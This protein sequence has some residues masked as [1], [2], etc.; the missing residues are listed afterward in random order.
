MD[1]LNNLLRSTDEPTEQVP[2]L[3]ELAKL[4]TSD[5]SKEKKDYASQ[6]LVIAKQLKSSE[7]L[8]QAHL[9]V[10]NAY[11]VSNDYEKSL[12]HSDSS[13]NIARQLNDSLCIA[14]NLSVLGLTNIDM[15]RKTYP[16]AE[17]YF[18]DALP[19]YQTL[20]DKPGQANCFINLSF[21]VRK[22]NKLKEAIDFA[23]QALAIGTDIN[24]PAILLSVNYQL[25]LCYHRKGNYEEALKAQRSALQLAK[26]LGNERREANTLNQISITLNRTG[27][28]ESSVEHSQKAAQIN[29]A[30]NDTTHWGGN[31]TNMGVSYSRLGSYHKSLEVYFE[32]LKLLES[33][34]DKQGISNAYTNIGKNYK[35]LKEY[36]KAME[37]YNRSIKLK[38][39]LNDEEGAGRVYNNL[40]TT[41]FEQGDYDTALD[42][43]F[44]SLELHKKT[45]FKNSEGIAL[46]NLGEAYQ[47]KQRFAEALDYSY[48]ALDI[49]S[50]IGNKGGMAAALN[51]IADTYIE[52]KKY[53]EQASLFK[54]ENKSAFEIEGMLMQAKDLAE[55]IN[56]FDDMR[57]V[58]IS[59][60][61]FY[62]KDNPEDALIFQDKLI[63]I[64]DSIYQSE[65]LAAATEM[66]TKFDLRNKEKE[67]EF[68]IETNTLI[69]TRNRWYLLMSVA[70]LWLLFIGLYFYVQIRKVKEQ[71]EVQNQTIENQ[72]EELTKLN[73][74]KDRFFGI[75][76]HDLKSPLIALQG[77][78]K[79]ID[80]L[81]RNNERDQLLA[82]GNQVDG[83][84]TK[85]NNLLDNLLHW[86]SIQSGNI[87]YQPQRLNVLDVAED[88][89]DLFENNAASKGVD[90][91]MDISPDLHIHADERAVNTI[92]RNLISNA[93]KFTPSGGLVSMTT[94]QQNGD[95]H[96]SL[97][98]SGEGIPPDRL[99]TIFSNNK[100][101]TRGTAGEKGTGLGLI[102]CK[103]LIELNKGQFTVQSTPGK[104][105]CFEFTLP[106][107]PPDKTK[108]P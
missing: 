60:I 68:L 12:A 78:G 89:M 70:L 50:D 27:D 84:S 20:N 73:N 80:F 36:D 39:E 87:P 6:A 30:R 62:R 54:L 10:A 85:L 75:I 65:K 26:Q 51:Y 106:L 24:D 53:P 55:E 58:Y 98:D 96:I 15:G 86:A 93:V 44:K 74:T 103:E 14:K 59:L 35:Q 94:S 97:K 90:L 47:K 49:F 28:Y 17:F 40:G 1:S 101:S 8:M 4:S 7:L 64:S 38:L 88:V 63:A 52:L 25:G 104:G 46:V 45:K 91:Q 72:N 22:K 21:L 5:F 32:A 33:Q 34:N 108:E 2:L 11:R 77:L 41:A 19:I 29:K 57:N 66:Q 82:L 79:R 76:A 48:Q 92:L 105:S 102:L 16:A 67:N 99:K 37:F 61:E 69:Q 100:K 23:N 95:A 81:L 56:N 71:L 18:L 31:L 43:Y 13:L 83:T 42:Y 107:Y 3:L 9:Q